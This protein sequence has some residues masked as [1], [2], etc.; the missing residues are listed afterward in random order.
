MNIMGLTNRELQVTQR[1]ARGDSQCQIANDLGISIHTVRSYLYRAK[2][3]TGS[4]TSI[5]LAVKCALSSRES[6]V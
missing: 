6:G 1:L 4:R 5:E 2:R 3:R